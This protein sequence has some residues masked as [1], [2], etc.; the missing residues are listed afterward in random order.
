[1]F[2]KRAITKKERA[3]ARKIFPGGDTEDVEDI[4]GAP[5]SKRLQGWEAEVWFNSEL[6]RKFKH[7]PPG[8]EYGYLWKSKPGRTH[9]RYEVEL[10]GDFF[11][12]FFGNIEVKSTDTPK[13]CNVNIE[14]WNK[15]PTLYVAVVLVQNK[16]FSLLGWNYGYEVYD[17]DIVGYISQPDSFYKLVQFRSAELFRNK[18]LKV[19]ELHKRVKEERKRVMEQ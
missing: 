6:E 5:D 4:I 10:V 11:I 9:H 3:I 16:K 2:E 1:M 8:G 19:A 7:F 15:E 18:L 14:R 12:D 13:Q 17:C